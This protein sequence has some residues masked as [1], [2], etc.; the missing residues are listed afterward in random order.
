[1]RIH[2]TPPSSHDAHV[3]SGCFD[4]NARGCSHGGD[5]RRVQR[6]FLK[7]LRVDETLADAAPDLR[8]GNLRRVQR[9]LSC[10]SS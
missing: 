10:V 2:C 7:L 6:V 5:L 9:E 3:V 4:G 1:M 8:V